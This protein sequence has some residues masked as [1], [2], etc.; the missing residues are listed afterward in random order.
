[1]PILPTS[2]SRPARWRTCCDRWVEPQ[3]VGQEDGV[4]GD[5]LGVALGVAVL[6]VDG[7]DEPLEDVE[8]DGGRLRLTVGLGDADGVATAGPCLV[9]R[10]GGDGQQRGDRPRR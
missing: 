10:L 4:A 1:M 5:V 9:E 2:W 6:G 8:A 3:P 7:D